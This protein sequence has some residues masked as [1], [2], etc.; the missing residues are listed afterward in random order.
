MYQTACDGDAREGEREAVAR[1]S[2]PPRAR[3][4]SL[5]S[6]FA[7]RPMD[8]GKTWEQGWAGRQAGPKEEKRTATA[9]ET[10]GGRGGGGNLRDLDLGRGFLGAHACTVLGVLHICNAGVTKLRKNEWG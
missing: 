8:R 5:P 1:R 9:T 6:F 10:G 2:S 3:A 7:S 4:R